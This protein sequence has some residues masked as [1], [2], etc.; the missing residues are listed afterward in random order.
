MA[1]ISKK[2]QVLLDEELASYKNKIIE[3]AAVYAE[4]DG[5]SVISEKQM[6]LAIRD[7]GLKDLGDIRYVD[8]KQRKKRVSLIMWLLLL[9][10]LTWFLICII[11]LEKESFEQSVLIVGILASSLSI[12]SLFLLMYS[13]RR[14]NEKKKADIVVAFLSEWNEF[15]SLLNYSYKGAN[16]GGNVPLT[17]LI[18]YYIQDISDNKSVDEMRI[19]KLLKIR[20]SLVHRGINNFDD[21]ILIRQTLE[22]QDMIKKLK[23]K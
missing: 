15:E 11:Y 13:T 19:V 6:K 4:H 2:A 12:A 1:V 16:K 10:S 17:D 5:D 22:L 20:N 3:R 8:A 18:Q 14:K 23:N 7:G 21:K 9:L